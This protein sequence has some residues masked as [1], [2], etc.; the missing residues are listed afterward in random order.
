VG[1]SKNRKT[2]RLYDD[3]THTIV[4][5]TSLGGK[6]AAYWRIEAFRGLRQGLGAIW[7][8]RQ[9][10]RQESPTALWNGEAPGMLVS[11]FLQSPRLP[12]EF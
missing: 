2:Y 7:L 8:I 3:A 9:C 5:G 10:R 12:L 11:Q 4:G 1:A 6:M